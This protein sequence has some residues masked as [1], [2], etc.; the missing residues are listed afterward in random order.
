MPS[1]SSSSI[2]PW[3]GRWSGEGICRRRADMGGAADL[4][5][6]RGQHR[7]IRG[8]LP[9]P[10]EPFFSRLRQ[11]AMLTRPRVPIGELK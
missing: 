9:L 1:R 6:K 3:S 11:R 4:F 10:D 2:S 5:E 8:M 7:Q